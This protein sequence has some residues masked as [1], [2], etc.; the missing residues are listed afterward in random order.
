MAD[1]PQAVRIPSGPV[2]EAL[3]GFWSRV[4][5]CKSVLALLSPG[6]TPGTRV[7][8]CQSSPNSQNVSV[9]WPP[10]ASFDGGRGE[11]GWRGVAAM[12]R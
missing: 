2:G 9:G 6:Y 1:T 7:D 5:P 8:I 3:E 12:S 4:L 10:L 11:G